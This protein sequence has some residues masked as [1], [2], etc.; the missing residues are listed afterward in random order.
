MKFEIDSIFF[1]IDVDYHC[2]N[3]PF[4]YNNLA[5]VLGER[6]GRS[7]DANRFLS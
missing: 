1:W 2:I 7:I 4:L 3:R 5:Q 6:H